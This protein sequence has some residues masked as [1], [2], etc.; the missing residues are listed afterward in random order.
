MTQGVPGA[1]EGEQQ[2]GRGAEEGNGAPQERA[3]NKVCVDAFA[4][5]VAHDCAFMQDLMQTV[6]VQANSQRSEVLQTQTAPFGGIKQ[7]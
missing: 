3:G 5:F 2:S 1:T 7:T 4:L 6:S